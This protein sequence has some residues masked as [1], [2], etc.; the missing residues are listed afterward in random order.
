MPKIEEIDYEYTT[1][2]PAAT[3]WPTKLCPSTATRTTFCAFTT[4]GTRIQLE[5]DTTPAPSVK[6]HKPV[7]VG[8]I[9]FHGFKLLCLVVVSPIALPVAGLVFLGRVFGGGVPDLKE[10]ARKVFKP[11]TN[12]LYGIS[13]GWRGITLKERKQE[14][15]DERLEA[16]K[17]EQQ[18]WAEM[19][20]MHEE[21]QKQAKQN[22][23][24]EPE[25]LP[26]PEL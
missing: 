8:L 20:K 19:N 15:K 12:Q 23:Q 5:R 14:A 4:R 6:E 18:E 2:S 10:D 3:W 9:A 1:A 13:A 7:K 21:K 26:P 25:S 22:I 17:R 11:L 16:R 24:I